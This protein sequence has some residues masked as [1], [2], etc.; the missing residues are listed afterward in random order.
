MISP[1]I[2]L[3]DFNALTMTP[4]EYLLPDKRVIVRG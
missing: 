1:L 4:Y 3:V 2:L